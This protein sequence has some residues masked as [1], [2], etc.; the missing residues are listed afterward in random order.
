MRWSA[1]KSVLLAVMAALALGMSA[2]GDD[3]DEGGGAGTVGK[4]IKGKQGGDLTVMYA[5]DVDNIDPAVAYYQYSFN[6]MYAT[7]RPLYN[8]KPD[9]QANPV[10]DLAADKPQITDGGRT[11]TVKIKKGIK[12]SPPVD[13]EVTTADV[14]YAIERGFTKNVPSGY[15]TAY[16]GDLEGVKAFQDGK[17]DEITGIQTPD[18]Q[19]IVFKLTKPRGAVLAGAL[20][21]PGSAPVPKEY[22]KKLDAKNPSQYGQNQ[23]ATGPYMVRNNA[24]GKLV[25][26]KPGRLIELVRNP[27][28]DKS[29]DERPAWLD[30]ITIK[31]G[32]DP[33][34]ASRQIINGQG[35]VNGDFQIPPATLKRVSE[36][37][38][39]DQLVLTPPTG[40]F[41]YVALN[42]RK[43]PFDDINVRKA[44]VAG[45][46]RQAM[47]QAF[48]GPITGD[49]PTHFI[50]PG[51][52]G[53]EEAGGAQ[54]AG[55]DFLAKPEG[56]MEVAAEYFRKAGFKSGKYEGGG[57]IQ[58]V[59][60][61]ATQ[62]KKAAEVAAAQLE[63]L[64]FDVEPRFVSRD[65][66]Y[67]KFCQVPKNE[68]EV[69][70]SVGWLKDFADPET[71]LGPTFKGENILDVSNSNFALLDVPAIDKAMDKAEVLVDPAERAKAW[72]AIDK[73]VT[74]AAP[75]VPWLWDRQPNL[76]SDDVQGVISL[77]N[78]TWDLSYTSL[79]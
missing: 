64:G 57:S 40:R 21:L 18:D 31:E 32:S 43:K 42:S 79:K 65:T 1:W 45:F 59:A 4:P 7:Q 69:C 5:G 19:T 56:D 76:R 23:V 51:Q 13:R 34:V 77:F 2:C 67:T 17:A 68:P 44:V 60:D 33:N 30:T 25:G 39:K 70:P 54:G 61:N 16:W 28:W 55:L 8:Y 15:A 37:A 63:K 62:Q 50:P 41:R 26:Y 66:M 47:R 38:S 71:I 49:I 78:A 29:T 27:N 35:M 10:P 46:D 9:D 36:G 20:A 22:A 11:V 74:A 3:D 12:F 24:K 73:Q 72:G 52:P 14:K 53:F 48:G 58:M 6:V 75:G